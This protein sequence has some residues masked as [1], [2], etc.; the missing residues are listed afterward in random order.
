MS[1]VMLCFVLFSV[2]FAQFFFFRFSIAID[3]FSNEAVVI[4]ELNFA[5]ARMLLY[6]DILYIQYESGNS[7]NGIE[8]K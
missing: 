2:F 5:F 4:I 3:P 6:K 1:H 7:F 8:R